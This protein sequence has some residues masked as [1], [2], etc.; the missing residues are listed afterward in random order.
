MDLP[1]MD[2]YSGN[3]NGSY[4][5][6]EPRAFFNKDLKNSSTGIDQLMIIML[7]RCDLARGKDSES[8]WELR[9]D[10]EFST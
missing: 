3:P 7:M 4:R 10:G 8:Q 5:R 9:T 6:G 2:H 1:L